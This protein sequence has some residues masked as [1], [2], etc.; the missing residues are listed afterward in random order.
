MPLKLFAKNLRHILRERKI[1]EYELAR[2]V[3]VHRASPWM[4]VNRRSSPSLDTLIKLADALKVSINT[5]VRTDMTKVKGK[6]TPAAK[7]A[8]NISK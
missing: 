5:L 7:L 3:G 1:S 4:W 8:K 6:P 2:R